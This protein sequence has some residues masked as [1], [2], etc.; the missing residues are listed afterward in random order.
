MSENNV[1]LMSIALAF[2]KVGATTFGGGYAMLPILRREVGAGRGWLSDEDM[3]D[4]YA[5]SQSM[6]GIIAVNTSVQLGYKLRGLAGGI[7]AAVG[8]ALPSL[9]I[10]M[11]IAAFI[12]RFDEIQW[13]RSALVGVRAVVLALIAD[14]IIKLFKTIRKDWLQIALF[15][16]VL[17]VML[18]VDLPP[19]A[20]VVGC[21]VI[22][23]VSQRARMTSRGDKP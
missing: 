15:A 4:A 1:S 18:V 19:V 10:I 9:V 5:L 11:I 22:G 23:V 14:T 8:V 20:I 17:I 21:A 2:M 12:G 16:A 7:A 6:P 3:M 13:V